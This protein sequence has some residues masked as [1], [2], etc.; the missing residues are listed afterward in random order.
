MLEINDLSFRYKKNSSLVL[1]KISMNLQEG[2]IGILLGK[3]GCGK[4]TLFK[5]ILGLCKPLCGEINFDGTDITKLSHKER[6]RLI[7]Y[8]PQTIHFG[9]LSVFD[10]ILLGRIAYFGFKAGSEDYEETEKIIQ[11]LQLEKIAHKSAENLSG[12]EKQKVAVARAL[13]QN[14]KILIFDEP[15]GNLDIANEY[16]IIE[17]TKKISRQKKISVLS[18][19]HDMNQALA[20]GDRFFFMKD[21]EIKYN[22]DKNIF[23]SEVL[24]D[25]YGIE[26]KIFTVE[27]H[28]MIAGVPVLNQ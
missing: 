25:I 11:E 16:L 12:G 15:T 8:V 23:S 3:N 7:G 28:I 4:T 10:S 5:N 9:S 22:G 21:G 26:T 13:V 14:P 27:N 19:F 18:S 2:E 24:R 1:N 20:L 6:A 17:E